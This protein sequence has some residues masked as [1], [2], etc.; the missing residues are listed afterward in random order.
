MHRGLLDDAFSAVKRTNDSA[1]DTHVALPTLLLGPVAALG[2]W[3]SIALPASYIPLFLS[4]VIDGAVTA[5]LV[6]LHVVAVL[7][8]HPYG[9]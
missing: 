4:G 2:F 1:A 8:G 3:A 6:A 7:A 9:R 5:Q